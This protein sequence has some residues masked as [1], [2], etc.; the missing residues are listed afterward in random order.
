MYILYNIIHKHNDILYLLYLRQHHVSIKK[1]H[2]FTNKLLY[3]PKNMRK[4]FLQELQYNHV[5]KRKDFLTK[6]LMN[7]LKDKVILSAQIYLYR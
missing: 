3:L 4:M 5:S 1:I 6:K 2:T 7:I